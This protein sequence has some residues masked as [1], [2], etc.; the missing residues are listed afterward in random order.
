MLTTATLAFALLGSGISVTSPRPDQARTPQ[1]EPLR[2]IAGKPSA[3]PLLPE[4]SRSPRFTADHDAWLSVHAQAA[5]LDTS[6]VVK[7]PNGV[8]LAED[9]DSGGVKTPHLWIRVGA[10]QTIEVVVTA[11]GEGE[12]E[13]ALLH[14]I[15]AR[16]TEATLDAAEEADDELAALKTLIEA[17]GIDDEARQRVGAL[18]AAL[19]RVRGGAT[20]REISGRVLE[21]ADAARRVGAFR[22]SLEVWEA[23][24]GFCEATLPEDHPRLAANRTNLA[25]PL[26]QASEF[27][28]AKA[29]FEKSLR[30]R[31]KLCSETDP[32]L[33][34]A[35]MNYG[36][37]C[38][39]TGDMETAAK[40][41]G[42]VLEI[43]EETRPADDPQL[44][45][46]RRNYAGTLS[47]LGD[48]EGAAAMIEKALAVQRKAP[49]RHPGLIEALSF[50][51]GLLRRI[52]RSTDAVEVF[53][54]VTAA[55]FAEATA[56]RV[57]SGSDADK[58]A[59]RP[60]MPWRRGS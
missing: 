12:S 41:L 21:V 26:F 52:G 10:G 32:L 27:E 20:S 33:V 36:N 46:V 17:G 8:T 5:T 6:L 40:M 44:Q 30:T 2:I 45:I 3:F 28:R 29:L 18:L 19:Q 48:L 24:V 51:A 15:E 53:E 25:V 39:A 1:E 54:E 37:A 34:R 55:M 7:D 56:S 31:V 50:H 57:L 35:R 58:T 16:E 14:L 47:D 38:A 59:I 13:S 60:R 9:D 42:Q 43:V 23:R 22:V 11:K 49:E 4:S